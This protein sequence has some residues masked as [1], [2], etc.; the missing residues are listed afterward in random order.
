MSTFLNCP[1]CFDDAN[2]KLDCGHQI[3]L[4]CK[5][6]IEAFGALKC[7]LCR[8]VDTRSGSC[9]RCKNN[10]ATA[11]CRICACNLCDVCWKSTHSIGTPVLHQQYPVRI[12]WDS[13][14][15]SH[16]YDEIIE[17]SLVCMSANCLG[18]QDLFCHRCAYM[19]HRKCDV[20]P[21][22]QYVDRKKEV[23]SHHIGLIEAGICGIENAKK[24]YEENVT[25]CETVIGEIN[26]K[27]K[28]A[29][30][31]LSQLEITAI[32]DIKSLHGV[33]D[34]INFSK[35]ISDYNE[36]SENLRKHLMLDDNHMFSNHIE[37]G[38]L[39][40]YPKVVPAAGVRF[41]LSES[42]YSIKKEI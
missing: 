12:K 23:I 42:N 9:D 25:K 18:Y 33:S 40:H 3:C 14:Y 26:E 34:G 8:R 37:I 24:I 10:T 2:I 15:C 38:N 35:Y 5:I 39:P 28:A 17:K 41:T 29:H 31:R 21:L 22:Y 1:V 4:K 36:I 20:I 11:G 7:P 6:N 16:G 30:E 27:F 13:V 19:N 32:K